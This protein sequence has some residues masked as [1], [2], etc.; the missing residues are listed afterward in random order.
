MDEKKRAPKKAKTVI[1]PR[2]ADVNADS[3]ADLDAVRLLVRPR[4]VGKRK[5]K[6]SPLIQLK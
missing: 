3:S 2:D 6:I 4:A 5:I 1:A